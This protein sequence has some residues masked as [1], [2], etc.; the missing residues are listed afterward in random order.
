MRDAKASA[1]WLVLLLLSI[2]T[3]VGAQ[4]YEVAQELTAGPIL[5]VPVSV[6][7]AVSPD[8]KQVAIAYGE[9]LVVRDSALHKTHADVKVGP[10][11]TLHFAADG[12]IYAGHWDGSV[13]CYAAGSGKRLWKTTLE[14][15]AKGAPYMFAASPDGKRVV[16]VG[17]VRALLESASGKIVALDKAPGVNAWFLS[18][19]RFA[20][21]ASPSQL[22]FF[23]IEKRFYW[24]PAKEINVPNVFPSAAHAGKVLGVGDRGIYEIDPDAKGAK[25]VF[26]LKRGYSNLGGCAR[27]GG[28]WLAWAKKGKRLVTLQLD[29]E[30]KVVAQM[31]RMFNHAAARDGYTALFH[32]PLG[33][34]CTANLAA[35]PHPLA[36]FGATAPHVRWHSGRGVE[37]FG[38]RSVAQWHPDRGDVRITPLSFSVTPGG[39]PFVRHAQDGTASWYDPDT[40]AVIEFK[41]EVPQGARVLFAGNH[42]LLGQ[43]KTGPQ[44][45]A[46]RSTGKQ[47]RIIDTDGGAALGPAGEVYALRGGKLRCHGLDGEVTWSHITGAKWVTA[48]RRGDR[49]VAGTQLLSASEG[50]VIKELRDVPAQA[51]FSHDG[52]ALVVGYK[53]KEKGT[54]SYE[55]VDLDDGQSS[56]ITLPDPAMRV[57]AVGAG[58]SYLLVDGPSARRLTLTPEQKQQIQMVSDLARRPLFLLRVSK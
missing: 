49:V 32:S 50:V 21:A 28:G 13:A 16:A 8:G 36:A 52:E 10:C 46:E 26:K 43:R 37:A 27:F 14:A 7:F 18:P 19:D 1:R 57:R 2:T 5:A 31:P 17:P 3:S 25:R 15:A 33:A 22:Q 53:H 40:R 30:F 20:I 56:A 45:L 12:K 55:R 11:T 48:S 34:I 42:I 24:S 58:G 41:S 29:D 54:R 35:E 23:D 38:D 47:I 6:K 9:R 44:M 51:L 39:D 4:S